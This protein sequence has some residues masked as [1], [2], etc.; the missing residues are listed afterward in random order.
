MKK[1]KASAREKNTAFFLTGRGNKTD[2]TDVVS[3]EKSFNT[4]QIQ[5]KSKCF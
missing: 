4:T 1:C 5:E 2:T 3:P